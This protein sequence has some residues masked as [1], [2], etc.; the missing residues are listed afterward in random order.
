[1]RIAMDYQIFCLQTYGG[2]S[3]YF[4]RLAEQLSLDS[5]SVKVFSPL[6]CNEY[7]EGLDP[8]LVEGRRIAKTSSKGMRLTL[9]YNEFVA[10]NKISAWQPD[11]EHETYYSLFNRA[12]RKHPVVITVYDMVH[13][14][15]PNEF[16]RV[17]NLSAR[18]L[19][20][21]QRADHVICISESTRRDLV[22]M[23]DIDISKVSVVHLGFD[24]FSSFALQENTKSKRER[25]YLLFVGN[26]SGYK[27]F[28]GFLKSFSISVRLK[29]DFDIVS[30][31][32]GAFSP[33]E[34]NIISGLGLAPSQVTQVS[35]GDEK[36]GE[37]YRE[38]AIFVYPSLYEGF[39]LPPLEAM[40]NDCPV[41]LSNTSSMPEVVGDAGAYFDPS[42]VEDMSLVIENLAF[43]S[44]LKQELVGKGRERLEVFSWHNC[45]RDTLA[46]YE[47]MKR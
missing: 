2:I 46:V 14:L 9:P 16:S 13:E 42:S 5:K 39:G 34:K 47:K 3:R 30:F 23:F 24:K 4:V 22:E 31:G 38:A 21:V 36:L 1:M 35:G 19:K 25:P 29:T 10:R 17:G 28:S 33:E 20:A 11:V 43:S 26:R 44:S 18:K 32:G 6:H 37:L 15:F 8:S 45:A 40:A 27:N 41:A 7:L 12:P